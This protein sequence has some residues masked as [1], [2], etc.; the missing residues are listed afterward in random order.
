MFQESSLSE[1]YC[2]FSEYLGSFLNERSFL[3]L[4]LN[5]T[6]NFLPIVATGQVRQGGYLHKNTQ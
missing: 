1:E 2:K 6:G 4:H 3:Q 5:R